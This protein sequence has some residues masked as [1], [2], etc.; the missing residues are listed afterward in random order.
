MSRCVSLVW[1]ACRDIRQIHDAWRGDPQ[2]YLL[3]D[4]SREKYQRQLAAEDPKRVAAMTT[5]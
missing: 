1:K 4:P 3:E 2:L 5:E